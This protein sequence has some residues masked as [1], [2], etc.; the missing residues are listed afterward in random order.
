MTW[1]LV[2]GSEVKNNYI[3]IQKRK[4]INT[5]IAEKENIKYNCCYINEI[6]G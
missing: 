4:L 6:E 3:I 5:E 2:S 1:V